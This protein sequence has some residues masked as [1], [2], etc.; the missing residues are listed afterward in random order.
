MLL[1]RAAG[2]GHGESVHKPIPSLPTFTRGLRL[3]TCQPFFPAPNQTTYR[4]RLIASTLKHLRAETAQQD[5]PR[6]RILWMP[7]E[8]RALEKLHRSAVHDKLF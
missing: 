4:R 2:N 6:R 5:V 8:A 7:L 1:V 3:L